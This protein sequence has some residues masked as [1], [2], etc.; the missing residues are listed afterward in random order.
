M[1]VPFMRAYTERLVLT[2][3]RRGAPAI[4]GMAAYIPSRRDEA[5]NERAMAKVREDKER[6][7]SD[8]FDGT[9]VAHP[10]LVPLA[11]EVFDA[12]LAGQP[13]QHAARRDEAPLGREVPGDPAALIDFHVPD[14][15]V[16]EAGVRLNVNVALRYL[17]SW[18]RGVGAAAI[19]DLMEDAATAEISRSQLWQWRDRGVTLEDGSR[20]DAE[21]YQQVHDEELW[22]IADG[23]TDQDRSRVREA[24][25]LLDALVLE[26]DFS[27]FLTLPA[28]AMLE[29]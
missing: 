4:G 5:V 21:R 9:W 7:S 16:T 27:E 17:N 12:V 19:N 26:D 29:G 2:C 20:F 15:R 28:Y 6:E 3:H 14:G 22:E 18:F 24:A 8:G 1:T 23:C 11:T 13:H 25:D 10:D